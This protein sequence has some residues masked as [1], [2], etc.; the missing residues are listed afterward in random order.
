[1]AR[2]QPLEGGTRSVDCSWVYVVVLSAAFGGS[3]G[4]CNSSQTKRDGERGRGSKRKREIETLEQRNL[5]HTKKHILNI[6]LFR[7]LLCLYFHGAIN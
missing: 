6:L 2:S 3:H 4:E 5:L 1:M 7:F